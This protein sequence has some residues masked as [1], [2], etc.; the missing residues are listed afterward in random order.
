[1]G[2]PLWQRMGLSSPSQRSPC[3]FISQ[4][5]G[6]QIIPPVIRFPLR[7]LLRLT[8][9][10]WSCSTP[11]S[12]GENFESQ[13]QSQNY[14]TTGGLPPISSFSW[15]APWDSWLVF[16]SR[17]NTCGNS[18]YAASSLTRGGVC[19]FQLLKTLASAIILRYES[20][21]THEHIL[22]SQIPDSSKLE[23]QV[24]IFISPKYRQ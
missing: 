5:Q 12:H 6:G 15:E 22:L 4:E 20:R 8:G 19:R 14:F 16:F 13:G 9:Q 10:R 23:G 1:M 18:P 21:G 3:I 24:P 11:P 7:R 2:R 17:P